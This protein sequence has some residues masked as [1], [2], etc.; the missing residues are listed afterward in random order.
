MEIGSSSSIPNIVYVSTPTF[1]A[2]INYTSTPKNLTTST[3]SD[4]YA[5]GRNYTTI[6][7]QKFGVFSK[8]ID[9]SVDCATFMHVTE[10]KGVLDAK[11][12]V[13]LQDFSSFQ[14]HSGIKDTA[15]LNFHSKSNILL[16]NFDIIVGA[17]QPDVKFAI[18]SG[19]V[20]QF[21]KVSA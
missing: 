18:S 2:E 12:C 10:S 15:N 5:H 1:V 6:D 11:K 8:G 3:F 19:A 13:I 17:E 20:N 7:N 14:N 4:S 21:C 9:G 16:L